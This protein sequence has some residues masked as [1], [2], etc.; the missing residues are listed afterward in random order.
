MATQKDNKNAIDGHNGLKLIPLKKNFPESKAIE[1]EKLSIKT[2]NQ[3]I[4]D[5]FD[6]NPKYAVFYL[7]FG[8]RFAKWEKGALVFYVQDYDA[9]YLQ[10]ARI[11]DDER[12]LKI[13][14]NNDKFFY[15]LR[16]DEP[17]DEYCAVEADQILWGTH[18][19]PLA[20]GWTKLWEERGTELIVP[21]EITIPVNQPVPSPR[22]CIR[23][24]DYIGDLGNGQASF[25]DCRFVALKQ[26]GKESI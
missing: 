10:L 21:F 13:W 22:A 12:E 14:K 2:L 19:E 8:I 16:T 3:T 26:I 6:G 18:T 15:R 9:E 23:T 11:F 1:K 5:Y 4:K 17:G 20:K 24:R 7:D 25:V